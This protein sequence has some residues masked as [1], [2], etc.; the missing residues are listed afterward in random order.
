MDK[1]TKYVDSEYDNDDSKHKHIVLASGTY[2]IIYEYRDRVFKNNYKGNM[3]STFAINDTYG[4]QYFK[5]IYYNKLVCDRDSPLVQAKNIFVTNDEVFIELEPM[6]DTMFNMYSEINEELKSDINTVD[7]AQKELDNIDKNGDSADFKEFT[8]DE[9][10]KML[11]CVNEHIDDTYAQIKNLNMQVLRDAL[12]C[13]KHLHAHRIMHC[14]IKPNNVLYTYIDGKLKFKLCDLNLGYI[15]TNEGYYPWKKCF[16]TFTYISSKESLNIT[17]DIY[18]LAS[19]IIDA[20]I[21]CK[22]FKCITQ[23]K[24]ATVMKDN[25]ELMRRFGNKLYQ[26]LSFMLDQ[27]YRRRAYIDDIE[28][29]LEMDDNLFDDPRFVMK[30]VNFDNMFER[31]RMEYVSKIV[32]KITSDVPVIDLRRKSRFTLI[33]DEDDNDINHNN[34]NL[35]D[36]YITISNEISDT[37]HDIHGYDRYTS[38]M[39]GTAFMKYYEINI[40][41]LCK[42]IMNR[43][44]S[45]GLMIDI[46]NL[47]IDYILKNDLRL[48]HK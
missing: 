35:P 12:D 31:H 32:S 27:N 13:I 38:F 17:S 20:N 21:R 26:I 6:H 43:A 16:G 1:I 5:E 45:N 25:P 41:K 15:M 39:M 8:H 4:V 46:K 14:D 36:D 47:C 11:K 28:M 29:L 23:C 22:N 7:T 44:K 10:V 3:I 33:T 24:F 9:I 30:T 2:S 40:T 19:T 48:L 34:L 18:M 37:L 42:N